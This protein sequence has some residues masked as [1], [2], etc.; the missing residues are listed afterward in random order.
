MIEF[1]QGNLIKEKT[2]VLVNTVN[3]VGV[4]GK[5]IALQFK[6]AFPENFIFY[7]QACNRGMVQPGKMLIFPTNNIIN[8][9]YIINFPTKR[10]WKNKSNIEDI[11]TGLK[12]LVA[13]VKRLGVSSIAIPP[14]GCGNGC[15]DWQEVKP[16][17]VSAF[18]ELPEVNVVLFETET[19]IKPVMNRARTLF[20]NSL[21]IYTIAGYELSSL[22][23]QK[24]AYFLQ[25]AGEPLNLEY[26]KHQYGP[27]SNNLNYVMQ[28]L[29]GHY[30]KGYKKGN[31]DGEIEILPRALEVTNIYLDSVAK[32]RLEQVSELI[33]G[34][35][36]PYGM[37]SLSSIHWVTKENL[38]AAEDPK[39]AI[40]L[41]HDWSDRKR[42]I[43]KPHHL[44]NAW[45]RLKE[46]GWFNQPVKE[47]IVV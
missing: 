4:M 26:V 22:E 19:T 3:C 40:A 28:L 38:Q 46:Q 1:K 23:C 7:K 25:E 30:I 43:F 29:E 27:Y 2:E 42:Q 36:D 11:K 21:D 6:L 45:Q 39:V 31:L 13:D 37:E 5:G 35:E 10:H 17:I 20:L 44:R 33:N 15:L 14:L 41:V 32:K 34:F 47:L 9:K 8:P 18:A 12:S 16:L 24:L